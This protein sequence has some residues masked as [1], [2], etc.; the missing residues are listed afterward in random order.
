MS[1]IGTPAQVLRALEAM[2]ESHKARGDYQHD[3]IIS[4]YGP[5][6]RKDAPKM[7]N[8]VKITLVE[9]K[10]MVARM[11]REVANNSA[12]GVLYVTMNKRPNGRPYL[13]F[14]QP[15]HYVECNGAYYTFDGENPLP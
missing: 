1:I 12:R 2:A 11:E 3:G 7:K 14:E 4:L 15:S 9:L 6:E 13:A 5:G 10:N 8:E